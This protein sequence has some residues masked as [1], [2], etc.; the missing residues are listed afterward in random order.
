MT[1]AAEDGRWLREHQSEL[2]S[3]VT[4]RHLAAHPAIAARFGP[5]GREKCLQDARYHVTYL[6][7]SVASDRPALFVDYTRWAG[8]MLAAR[9]IPREDLAGYLAELAELI[10]VMHP[11][12]E[13]TLR[14]LQAGIEG[15]ASNDG[16]PESY[17]QK[18]QPLDEL[19]RTYFDLVLA[20]RRHE[21]MDAILASAEAGV[22]IRDLYLQ[23]FQPVQREVGRLWQ[24]GD[25]SVAQ[26]HFCTAVTQ[27]TLARLYPYIFAHQRTDK[28]LVATCV[29]DDLH[30]IGI[31]M[32]ADF[33]EMEGWETHY[34]GAN[35]PSESVIDLV[36]A[37]KA[38]VLAISAT[39]TT[40]VDKV[41]ELI[42][43]LR[44][45]EGLAH[46]QVIVGGYPFNVDPDLWR[47]VGADATAKDGAE[48][49]AL[50]AVLSKG[51]SA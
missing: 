8:E 17:I 6:A 29:S 3:Q 26:E 14:C 13:R 51:T 16:L 35:M 44:A 31:R 49:Q 5:A 18:D 1:E 22:S 12:P 25:I 32:I 30:E 43:Q 2:A 36:A 11:A 40:H 34:L 9:K 46:V 47:T 20:G 27:F 50:A 10:R 48:I 33:F 41:R 37:R 45:R 24:L 23:V 19:A 15:L 21:A 4:D 38:D 7:E 42:A 28:V 39:I